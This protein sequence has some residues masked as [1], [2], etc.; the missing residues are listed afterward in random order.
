[1]AFEKLKI[2]IETLLHSLKGNYSIAIEMAGQLFTLNAHQRCEAASVIKI[3]ILVEAYRQYEEGK[4]LLEQRLRIPKEQRVGGSGVLTHLSLEAT[5]TIKD[6]LTLM[7][8]VSDNTATNIMIDLLGRESIHQ[9]C[10]IIGCHHTSL[11]RK[12][13]DQAAIKEGRHNVISAHDILL[14][15]REIRNGERLN[16]T[17]RREI[18]KIMEA[19]QLSNK[20]P[21][22]I[23]DYG[24]NDPVIA[25][26]TGEVHGVEHDVGIIQHQGRE[27]LVVIL[28]TDLESNAEGRQVIGK[29]G[30]AIIEHM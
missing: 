30:K 20:L 1:M 6:L 19:Q 24:D 17:S 9:L 27:A 14:F 15:L 29:I 23:V 25:H 10:Q 8:I 12:L 5:L 16:E 4:I 2:E 11:Q 21:S 26:K 3:P 22:L 18:I 13:F 28:L 7:I